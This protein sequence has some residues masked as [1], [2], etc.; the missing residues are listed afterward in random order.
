MFTDTPK[1]AVSG[2]K[3]EDINM[4]CDVPV[5]LQL[6]IGNYGNLNELEINL[7]EQWDH[8]VLLIF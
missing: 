1:V 7:T 4:M 2:W 3:L 6:L 8:V 5:V